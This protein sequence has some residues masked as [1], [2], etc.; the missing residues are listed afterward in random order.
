MR[1]NEAHAVQTN[2]ESMIERMQRSEEAAA[3]QVTEAVRLEAAELVKDLIELSMSASTVR[4]YLGVT[5]SPFDHHI[6]RG[7]EHIWDDLQQAPQL[8]QEIM[9]LQVPERISAPRRCTDIAV[10]GQHRGSRQAVP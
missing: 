5:S 2:F 3:A 1:A 7:A 6:L 8:L 10:S 4:A 9:L